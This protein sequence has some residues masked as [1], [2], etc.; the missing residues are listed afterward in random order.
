MQGCIAFTIFSL[1]DP[2]MIVLWN[3]ESLGASEQLGVVYK[4]L[5]YVV[6]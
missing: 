5:E 4:V 1:H 3:S 6:S 2:E